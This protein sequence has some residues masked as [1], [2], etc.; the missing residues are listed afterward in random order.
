[1]KKQYR[2]YKDYPPN[3]PRK[4]IKLFRE[5]HEKQ[6]WLAHRLEI[7]DA[8]LSKLFKYGIEPKDESIRAK[9]FL[10]KIKVKRIKTEHKKT[11]RPDWLNE[12][13]HL[14]TDERQKVIKQYI[15]WK[16]KND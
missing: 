14:P 8:H 7:N 10:K 1:M 9:M 5:F 12:W 15:D 3:V 2:R 4:L 11:P 6:L 13:L 16:K